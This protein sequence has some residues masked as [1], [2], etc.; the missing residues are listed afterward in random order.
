[1]SAD[2]WEWVVLLAAIERQ[3]PRDE[4]GVLSSVLESCCCRLVAATASGDEA[5]GTEEHH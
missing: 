2:N 3:D 1:M 4:A 5:G